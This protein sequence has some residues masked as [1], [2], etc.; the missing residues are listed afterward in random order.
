[1]PFQSPEVRAACERLGES[2]QHAEQ[3]QYGKAHAWSCASLVHYFLSSTIVP[4]DVKCSD[5]TTRKMLL[6]LGFLYRTNDSRTD[7]Q[8]LQLVT[9]L[10]KI[11]VEDPAS[12]P[13][14]TEALAL[15]EAAHGDHQFKIDFGIKYKQPW[16]ER[17]VTMLQGKSPSGN[18]ILAP[19]KR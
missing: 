19:P 10:S 18:P 8:G 15:V 16:G 7:N 14:T 6:K 4:N 11:L 2:K 12:R 13:S 17:F 1:M 3:V 5:K 9:A